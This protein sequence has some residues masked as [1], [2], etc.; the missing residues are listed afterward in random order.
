MSSKVFII[1]MLLLLD[2]LRYY[3]YLHIE[4]LYIFTNLNRMK[5][6]YIIHFNYL[7][8]PITYLKLDFY[9]RNNVLNSLRYLYPSIV[10]DL[11]TA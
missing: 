3:F 8:T 11:F 5:L 7:L 2:N 10:F 1:N 4:L 9:L 6:N